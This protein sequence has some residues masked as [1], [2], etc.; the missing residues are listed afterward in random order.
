M[1]RDAMDTSIEH[2]P[3]PMRSLFFCGARL[4][5]P[6][7]DKVLAV[8]DAAIRPLLAIVEDPSLFMADAVGGGHAPIHAAT[9]LGEL[10]ATEAVGPLVDALASG[11]PLDLAHGPLIDALKKLGPAVVDVALERLARA[12]SSDER[13]GLREVLSDC[14]VHDDRILAALTEGLA[15]NPALGASNLA[16]Y[17]DP[18]AL[19]ALYAA[20]ERRRPDHDDGPFAGQDLID[21]EDAI[22]TLDGE[23]PP[24][25]RAG[26]VAVTAARAVFRRKLESALGAHVPTSVRTRVGRND[27]CPC[28]SA[29]KYKKCCLGRA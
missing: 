25:L 29:K 9:L 15:E 8:G 14:G 12:T 5:A 22:V 28:G 3:E 10:Q 11:D 21:L 7:R 17:G 2:V 27:P 26:L 13:G 24:S 23:V 16:S 19:P 6:L 1:T 20:A 18:R 4:P